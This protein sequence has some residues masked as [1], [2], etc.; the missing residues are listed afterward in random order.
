M[1]NI[2]DVRSKLDHSRITETMHVTR[3]LDS[4]M[5]LCGLRSARVAAVDW[6]QRAGGTARGPFC[7][8]CESQVDGELA[9]ERKRWAASDIT[10][11]PS[12]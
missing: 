2:S 5:T 6:A 1:T 9:A 7:P 11:L 3:P 8:A 4:T 10:A 12:E